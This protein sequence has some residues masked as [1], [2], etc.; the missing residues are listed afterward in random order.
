MSDPIDPTRLPRPV[1]PGLAAEREATIAR[2]QDA[3]ATSDED[4]FTLDM[5]DERLELAMKAR[6]VD[7]LRVLTRDLPAVVVPPVA[8]PVPAVAPAVVPEVVAPGDLPTPK[9]SA[10]FSSVVRRGR[11]VQPRS[12]KV[13]A[14][15]GSVVIDLREATFAPGV[16]TL[17]CR[18]VFG[19]IEVKVP[20]H[21]RV[22]LGGSGVFGSFEEIGDNALAAAS[23]DAPVLHIVGKAVFSSVEVICRARKRLALPAPSAR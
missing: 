22:E 8:A 12:M 14:V 15:F 7:E 17:H 1:V 19:S 16:T 5:L 13:R 23:P 21:V 18:S 20:P 9:V 6:S 10:I 11:R 2:L 4:S 3:A